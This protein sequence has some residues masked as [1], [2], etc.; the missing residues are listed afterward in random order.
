MPLA[1]AAADPPDDPPVECSA[2]PRV[3]G[4]REALWLRG[5]RR[6]ELGHVRPTQHDEA[7]GAELLGQKRAH[8]HRHRRHRAD[9]ERRR[10]PGHGRAE[11]LEQERHAAERAIGQDPARLLARLVEPRTDHRV[12]LWIERLDTGDRLVDQLLRAHLPAS[13]RGPPAR[14]RPARSL[15]MRS[16]M[17]RRYLID[18]EPDRHRPALVLVGATGT[19]IDPS[20]LQDS[21]C[22]RISPV[23]RWSCDAHTH[24]ASRWKLAAVRNQIASRRGRP[25]HH[26][27]VTGHLERLPR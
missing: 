22:S 3:A 11:V 10:L 15:S 26:A 20:G 16:A 17:A 14:S 25:P 12:E 13:G 27:P 8:G 5:D 23:T 19:Q 24:L 6:A 7:G 1:T 21:S 4:G 18:L 9:A 2:V